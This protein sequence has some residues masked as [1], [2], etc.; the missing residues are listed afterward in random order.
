[1]RR[2][3]FL[4]VVASAALL[5][6]SAATA[7]PQSTI[8]VGPP[9]SWGATTGLSD[10]PRLSGNARFAAFHSDASN[11]VTGDENGVRDIFVVDRDPDGDGVHA[12][13]PTV[14]ERITTVQDPEPDADGVQPPCL[15]GVAER[16]AGP[17]FAPA[18]DQSGRFVA[19]LSDAADP[20]MDDT[21]TSDNGFTD[22]YLYDRQRRTTSLVSRATQVPGTPGDRASG[23]GR[24]PALGGRVIAYTSRSKNI[25]GGTGR[26]RIV[27]T[28]TCAGASGAVPCVP[29]SV[30]V[31]LP[32]G[33]SYAHSPSISNMGYANV[34]AGRLAFVAVTEVSQAPSRAD[35]YEVTVGPTLTVGPPRRISV[36]ALE[37]L[38]LAEAEE[39]LIIPVRN[40]ATPAVSADGGSVAFVTSQP[41]AL[42]DTN[43]VPDVYVW[44]A[45]RPDRV[46]RWSLSSEGAEGDRASHS[47]SI[48]S[49]G[50]VVAFASSSSL[51]VPGDD[52]GVEDVFVRARERDDMPA[53]TQIVSL[54]PYTGYPFSGPSLSPAISGDGSTVVFAARD[55]GCCTEIMAHDRTRCAYGRTGDDPAASRTADAVRYARQRVHDANVDMETSVHFAEQILRPYLPE[56]HDDIHTLHEQLGDNIFQRVEGPTGGIGGLAIRVACGDV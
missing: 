11:L 20:A 14:T 4:A 24:P 55:T 29:Q 12:E 30:L 7:R 8:V 26:A 3:R 45:A 19:F 43:E 28:D 40:A 53:A 47:P 17:S 27:L 18:I 25:A 10:L 36:S 39:L 31:P 9:E 34:T 37:R 42:D 41:L 15:P 46:A 13:L 32:P 56:H 50:S 35:V 1:M 2:A 38:D 23:D 54:R 16:C 51:L 22:V 33:A 44:D 52:N 49:D 5:S 6:S 21:V 48:S